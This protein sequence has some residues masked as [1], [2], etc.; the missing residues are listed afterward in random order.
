MTRHSARGAAAAVDEQRLWAR[1]LELA[2]IGGTPAGGVNRQAL[3]REDME[4]RKVFVAWGEKLGLQP[5]TDSIGNVFLH[6]AGAD[7]A[8]APVLTGSHLDTQPS[9]GRFD[10]IFG[11]L[12]GLEALEAIAA[13]GIATRRPLEVAAW[14]NEEGC[15]FAPGCMGSRVFANPDQLDA[16]LAARD[17]DGVTVAEALAGMRQGLPGIAARPLGGPVAAYLEAHIEQ[18]P[19]LEASSTAI[20]VV[21]G[22][23]GRRR[24]LVEVHGEDAHAGTMPRRRRRDAFTSAVAMVT[25]L[26]RLMDDP[27]DVVRF[28]IG[29]F[30]VS[31]NAPSVVPG[32]VLF[33]ID[34]RHPDAEALTRLGDQVEPVCRARAGPCAVTIT[35]VSRTEPVAFHGRIP[36]TIRSAAE[37]LGLSRMPILSGAGHDAENLAAVCPTGML[38]VPCRDGISHSARE[39][40]EPAHLAAG[41]RVLAETLVDIANV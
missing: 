41:A 23:Q 28:T 14:T 4:A 19:E 21:T 22:I 5:A 7:P 10:G 38:F 20:G 29:R 11:V 6:R 13:A 27:A 15:R 30:L 24:F 18:G 8:A 26:E 32:Q 35:Q 17:L 9:G 3:T 1:H 34:F 39:Y 16:M 36:D 37:R 33:T 12:A 31:P 40:A 25:A 2:R